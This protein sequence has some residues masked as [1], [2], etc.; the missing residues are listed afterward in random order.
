MARLYRLHRWTHS[1]H[2][3]FADS[4]PDGWGKRIILRDHAKRRDRAKKKAEPF[5]GSMRNDLDYLLAVDDICRVFA[6]RFQDQ[7]G[8]F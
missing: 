7:D 1:F 2:G 5:A 3:V 8:V 6:L 4:A